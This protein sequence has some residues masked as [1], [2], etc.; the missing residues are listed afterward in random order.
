MGF[1]TVV[2]KKR[3]KLSYSLNYLI[4]RGE[5]EY[6]INLQ[7]I[8]TLIIESTAVSL[9][10]SL[11]AELSNRKVNVIFCNNKHNPESQLMPF[12][13]CHN[14]SLKIKEQL[15]W[16]KKTK[17]EIWKKIVEQ[18]ID[19]QKQNLELMNCEEKNMLEDYSLKVKIGDVTNREGHAAKVYFNSF[20]GK[21]FTRSS[22]VFINTVLNYGYTILL[23]HIN[24]YVVS[25]GYL[26]QLGI[27]HK[28]EYNDFNFSCDLVEP[29][30]PI[31]DRYAI[32]GEINEENFKKKLSNLDT[33]KLIIKD[34]KTNLEN[35]I[36]IFCSSVFKALNERKPEYIE[37]Y[38]SYEF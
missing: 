20:F 34:Q 5:E 27:H 23:S 18:K 35:G 9:T 14:S 16:T 28:S 15:T 33:I 24:R 29:F 3:C 32:S 37:M 31:I 12:Y 6:K 19:A 21:D 8:S 13:G 30:R 2:I 17:D 11:I 1:R 7:E 38:K 36:K 4:Y 25:S 10:S 26:T 22:G